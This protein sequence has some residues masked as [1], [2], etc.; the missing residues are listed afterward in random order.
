M[1][2]VLLYSRLCTLSENRVRR[3]CSVHKMVQFYLVFQNV[4]VM[5]RIYYVFSAMIWC[6]LGLEAIPRI[7]S[8]TPLDCKRQGQQSCPDNSTYFPYSL[9][10]ILNFLYVACSTVTAWLYAV[11]ESA[12]LVR[13]RVS[14]GGLMVE[15]VMDTRNLMGFYPIRVCVWA[16]FHTHEFVNG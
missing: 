11:F 8:A 4:L 9:V 13:S 6:I 16:N 12:R 15:M 2:C 14:F 7:N 3:L 5:M 1:V 10:L